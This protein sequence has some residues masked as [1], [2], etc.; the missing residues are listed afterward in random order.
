VASPDGL[1]LKPPNPGS[2]GAS[3]DFHSRWE[4]SNESSWSAPF[5]KECRIAFEARAEGQA[6]NSSRSVA[7]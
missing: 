1:T 4:E 6:A 3:E 5:T 7:R 2:G